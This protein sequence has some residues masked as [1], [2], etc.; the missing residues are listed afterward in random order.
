MLSL[1]VALIIQT[2]APLNHLVV[3]A[4]S[5]VAVN[6]E[7][8]VLKAKKTQ[9]SVV[10]RAVTK[11]AETEEWFQVRNMCLVWKHMVGFSRYKYTAEQKQDN[12]HTL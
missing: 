5:V 11:A 6:A 9:S 3:M 7:V 8:I 10:Y 12:S 4:L 2:Q 1:A